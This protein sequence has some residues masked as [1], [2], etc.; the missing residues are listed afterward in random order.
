MET[1]FK[2]GDK[3]QNGKSIFV[4]AETG[5]NH[6]NLI[7]VQTGKRYLDVQ[8]SLEI[9]TIKINGDGFVYQG[10]EAIKSYKAAVELSKPSSH[11]PEAV[12]RHTKTLN[13]ISNLI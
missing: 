13:F 12:E 9:V 4:L 7:N 2:P 10:P 8:S 5:T 1:N 3:F 6:Y 11:Y